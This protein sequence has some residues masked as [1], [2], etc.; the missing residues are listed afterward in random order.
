MRTAATGETSEPQGSLDSDAIPLV[1][2]SRAKFL[3]SVGSVLPMSFNK[4]H[5]MF[6]QELLGEADIWSV[7][8]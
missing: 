8:S 5:K 2:V 7:C 4:G 1:A 3:F 6:S